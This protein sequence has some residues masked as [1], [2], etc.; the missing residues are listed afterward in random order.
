MEGQNQFTRFD[1]DQFLKDNTPIDWMGNFTSPEEDGDVFVD[2]E[3]RE[4]LMR[5]VDEYVRKHPEV[6]IQPEDFDPNE[7]PTRTYTLD[8]LRK[9]L[10]D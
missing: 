10:N 2:E 9:L 7:K 3:T 8:E 1:M 6:L 5:Q 4:E